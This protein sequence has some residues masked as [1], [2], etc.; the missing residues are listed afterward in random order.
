MMG[1]PSTNLPN[2]SFKG[3]PYGP[4]VKKVLSGLWVIL[5]FL[6]QPGFGYLVSEGDSLSVFL[7]QTDYDKEKKHTLDPSGVFVF[8]YKSVQCRKRMTMNE[9]GVQ[10][11][12]ICCKIPSLI[13]G[14]TS[15][16][17][18]DRGG[19]AEVATVYFYSEVSICNHPNRDRSPWEIC[20]ECLNSSLLLLA[21]NRRLYLGLSE[22][23]QLEEHTP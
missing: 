18:Q 22:I 9:L 5:F 2:A 8:L 10:L 16:G 7:A 13:C 11:A 15:S 1:L 21:A 19:V 12:K 20:S 23:R 4:F 17:H 3:C 6:V 14:Y